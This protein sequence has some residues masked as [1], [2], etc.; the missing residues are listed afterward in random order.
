MLLTIYEDENGWVY[1]PHATETEVWD[2][3]AEGSE[4]IKASGWRPYQMH[5]ISRFVHESLL[6]D[7]FIQPGIQH[8]KITN[9]RN[10]TNREKS[11][12]TNRS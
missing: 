1:E 11:Q 8:T 3:T 9:P 6:I 10:L 5:R 2:T 4:I 7:G 12:I